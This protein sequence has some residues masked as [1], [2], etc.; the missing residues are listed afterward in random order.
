MLNFDALKPL[1]GVSLRGIFAPLFWKLVLC[2]V[3]LTQFA[4]LKKICVSMSLASGYVDCNLFSRHP[5]SE[6]QSM[7]FTVQ[8]F[9]YLVKRTVVKR[10]DYNLIISFKKFNV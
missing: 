8:F 3:G 2:K 6:Y 1:S 10:G 4:L 7:S 9:V 5:R